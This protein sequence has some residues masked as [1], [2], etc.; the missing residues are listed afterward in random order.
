MSTPM[1]NYSFLSY[2]RQGL[3][4]NID[5]PD[6]DPNVGVRASVTVTL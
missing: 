4:N 2:L 1:G 3:A 5:T 6:F